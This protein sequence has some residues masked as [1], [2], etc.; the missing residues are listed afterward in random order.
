[1]RKQLME[2]KK[3]RENVPN[4]F[5]L[6]EQLL[7]KDYPYEEPEEKRGVTIGIPKVLFYWET[8]PFWRT[9]W[10]AL[11]FSIRVSP[12]S[13]RQ[14]YED[15]LSAVTSTRSASGK[16]GPRTYSGTCKMRRGPHLHAV[17][18]HG[19]LGEHGGDQSVHVRHRQRISDRG[20][21]LR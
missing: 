18:H 10:R 6:R 20:A 9:F 21:Q 19:V 8:M 4:L 2:K 11:G 5:A 17:H 7:M 12:D 16:T 14:I 13:T 15:G 1:M 3:E